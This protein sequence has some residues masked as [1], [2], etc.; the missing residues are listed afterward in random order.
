MCYHP[1]ACEGLG[2]ETQISTH[3]TSCHH[4]P[5]VHPWQEADQVSDPVKPVAE[6]ANRYSGISNCGLLKDPHQYLWLILDAILNCQ[7]VGFLLQWIRQHRNFS[8]CVFRDVCE[9]R[10]FQTHGYSSSSEAGL[11]SCGHPEALSW[12][13]CTPALPAFTGGCSHYSGIYQGMD[14]PQALQKGFL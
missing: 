2:S 3:E 10:F 14:C 11:G 1:E 5:A 4:H 8:V 13:S 6:K 12:L 7:T 9:M